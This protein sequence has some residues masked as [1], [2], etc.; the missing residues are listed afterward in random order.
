[1]FKKI[2]SLSLLGLGISIGML[3]GNR[4]TI[5]SSCKDDTDKADDVVEK[6]FHDTRIF[7]LNI[8]RYKVLG[9]ALV[10]LFLKPIRRCHEFSEVP[11]LS[12]SRVKFARFSAILSITLRSLKTSALTDHIGSLI[13]LFSKRTCR[14]QAL[15]VWRHPLREKGSP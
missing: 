10:F 13:L 5:L 15:P 3:T 8:D 14:R 9:A 12:S 4:G 6:F 2:F 1:M 7:F 11:F